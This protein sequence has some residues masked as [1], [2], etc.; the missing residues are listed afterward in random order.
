NTTAVEAMRQLFDVDAAR[1]HLGN[2]QPRPGI[3]P[4]GTAPVVAL[5][6]DGNRELVEMSW[7]FRH[8]RRPK[9]PRHFHQLT[10]AVIIERDHWRG[11]F[12]MNA[13][14]RLRVAQ[15]VACRI[16]VEQLPHGFNSRGVRVKITHFSAPILDLQRHHIAFQP[17]F[18]LAKNILGGGAYRRGQTA[19]FSIRSALSPCEN[20][21]CR[22]HSQQS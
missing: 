19:P 20:A 14:A 2:A 4:K 5:D 15:L 7:G 18:H 16:H 11:P 22:R 1:D 21:A 8:L 13:W 17:V 12:R 10:V 6:D 3:H 9:P